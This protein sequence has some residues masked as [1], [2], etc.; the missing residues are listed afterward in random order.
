VYELCSGDFYRIA[1]NKALNDS[2]DQYNTH[3]WQQIDIIKDDFGN[4]K[5]YLCIKFMLNLDQERNE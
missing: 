4:K 5:V 1:Y 3:I 2:G